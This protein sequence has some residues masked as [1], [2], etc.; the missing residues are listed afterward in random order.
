MALCID[1]PQG[2]YN[3]AAQQISEVD[4]RLLTTRAPFASGSSQVNVN[5][6]DF[7]DGSKK[8]ALIFPNW[9]KKFPTDEEC[10]HCHVSLSLAFRDLDHHPVLACPLCRRVYL[11]KGTAKI[12][13]Q[14]RKAFQTNSC[15]VMSDDE[16]L[17]DP[18]GGSQS[19]NLPKN[20]SWQDSN[21]IGLLQPLQTPLKSNGDKEEKVE[22][23]KN[24]SRWQPGPHFLA[25]QTGP[26]NSSGKTKNI[27]REELDSME[28]TSGIQNDEVDLGESE[29]GYRRRYQLKFHIAIAEIRRQVLDVLGIVGELYPNLCQCLQHG[30]TLIFEADSAISKD[31]VKTLLEIVGDLC[32]FHL[33]F[34]QPPNYEILSSRDVK[35]LLTALHQLGQKWETPKPSSKTHDVPCHIDHL[36]TLI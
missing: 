18:Q 16:R 34:K 28:L 27:E 5:S 36:R 9:T 19:S 31:L 21:H 17:Q 33:T 15:E 26:A 3:Q 6:S 4:G 25:L 30:S 2:V 8:R 1:S 10:T 14:V 22:F 11:S 23:K 7:Q 20:M 32:H 35:I 12:L 24:N 29:Q 13:S